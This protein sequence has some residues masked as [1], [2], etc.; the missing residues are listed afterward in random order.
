VSRRSSVTRVKIIGHDGD[1]SKRRKEVELPINTVPE[2]AAKQPEVRAA[3]NA[4]KKR[5]QVVEVEVKGLGKIE[6]D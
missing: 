1:Q 4:F 3:Y 6:M 5:F 2:I